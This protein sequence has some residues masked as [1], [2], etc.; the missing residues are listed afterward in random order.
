MSPSGGI[1]ADIF[2]HFP[3]YHKA[4][5]GRGIVTRFGWFLLLQRAPF[6]ISPSQ[7]ASFLNSSPF[8][9][10]VRRGMGFLAGPIKKP[11]CQGYILRQIG[12]YFPAEWIP[13]FPPPEEVICAYKIITILLSMEN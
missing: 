13:V 12:C 10:E 6:L 5:K 1:Q 8:K 11:I 9:G 7:G 4:L 2:S 3:H